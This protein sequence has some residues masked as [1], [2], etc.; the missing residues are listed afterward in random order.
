MLPQRPQNSVLIVSDSDKVTDYLRRLLPAGQ[1]TVTVVSNAGE[2]KRLFINEHYDIA[3]INTPLPDEFG[4]QLALECSQ[5]QTMGIILLTKSI[6]YEQ[7]C[8]EMESRGIIT[9]QKPTS[10]A[11]I[12]QAFHL[13]AA[14]QAKIKQMEEKTRKLEQQLDEMRLL[15]RAKLLLIQTMDMNEA[16][17][18]RYIEKQAM[19][20]C[21]KKRDI[22]ENIIRIYGN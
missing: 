14:A 16:E 5:R 12:M 10:A 3:V 20:A 13:L 17:A 15:S 2:A 18:H 19:D 4:T 7:V 1:Y 11:V 9:I 22:A 6:S 8:C 21:C